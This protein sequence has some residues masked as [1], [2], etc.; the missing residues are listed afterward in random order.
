MRLARLRALSYCPGIE[1]PQRTNPPLG[2]HSDRTFGALAVAARGVAERSVELES[3]L[4]EYVAY[5]KASGVPA[6]DVVITIKQALADSHIAN[7]S[8]T[9]NA[10]A[11]GV[12]K[13]CI[14]Q[15]YND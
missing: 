12:V 3:A 2:A 8:L 11:H 10:F 14:D 15:F 1:E 9:P 13:F 4:T 5:L 7:D 6:E